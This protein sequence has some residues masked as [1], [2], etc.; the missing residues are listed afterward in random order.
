M[1]L[2]VALLRGRFFY[3]DTIQRATAKSSDSLYYTSGCALVPTA[4]RRAAAPC[5][6]G[7]PLLQYQKAALA[8]SRSD[9]WYSRRESNPQRPLR[10]CTYFANRG[11]C[12]PLFC[13]IGIKIG[14]SR[15]VYGLLMTDFRLKNYHQI[16]FIQSLY[17]FNT[18]IFH[19]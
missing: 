13:K 8:F 10:S 14:F 11:K 4:S 15:W 1:Y 5:A 2:S 18:S 12:Y 7:A 19:A 3:C 16:P 6:A 9:F 17:Q